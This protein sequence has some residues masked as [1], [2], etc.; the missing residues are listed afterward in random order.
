MTT[1]KD[2]GQH[3]LVDFVGCDPETL[4]FVDPTREIF[5]RAARESKATVVGEDF[6]Q[7]EPEGVSGVVLIAESHLS[8]HTWPED[9]FAAVDIF[10]CGVEMEADLAIAVL[11]DAFRAKQTIVK[12]VTRGQLDESDTEQPDEESDIG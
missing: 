2:Y 12:V 8:V 5:L 10:T 4:R 7:F 6:Y 3:Y 11:T 9:G 1:K